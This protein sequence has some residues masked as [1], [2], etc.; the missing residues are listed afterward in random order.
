[1]PLV[2]LKK[3]A[4]YETFGKCYEA[5]KQLFFKNL[6]DQRKNPEDAES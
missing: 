4:F 5:F 1:M 3:T 6:H 2:D